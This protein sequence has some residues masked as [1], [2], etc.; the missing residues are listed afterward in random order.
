[1]VRV[2]ELVKG[3]EG[4]R[5]AVVVVGFLCGIQQMILRNSGVADIAFRRLHDVKCFFGMQPSEEIDRA[6]LPSM[7]T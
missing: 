1:M 7:K 6:I 3:R 5:E 4:C 2:V